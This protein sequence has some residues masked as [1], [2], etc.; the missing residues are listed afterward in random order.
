M[1][2]SSKQKKSTDELKMQNCIYVIVNVDRM[3]QSQ[4]INQ[5]YLLQKQ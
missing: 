4:T 3:P 5:E 1:H 2:K